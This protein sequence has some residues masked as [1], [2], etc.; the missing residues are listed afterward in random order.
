[1]E[2][3][4]EKRGRPYSEENL[5]SE[6]YNKNRSKFWCDGNYENFKDEERKIKINFE[7]EQEYAEYFRG[8]I[9]FE[10]DE[11]KR[12]FEGYVLGGII[13][14]WEKH[15]E[16]KNTYIGKTYLK[17]G[18]RFWLLSEGDEIKI[19]DEENISKFKG[20]IVGFG[21]NFVRFEVSTKQTY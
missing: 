9:N 2:F 8:L 15:R 21:T 6:N 11:E 7:S 4:H 16:K 12:N 18:D 5:N 1:M 13:V 19:E 10:K 20:E 14:D 17:N 3:P